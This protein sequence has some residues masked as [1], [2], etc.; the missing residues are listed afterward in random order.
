MAIGPFQV[1]LRP[2]KPQPTRLLPVGCGRFVFGQLFAMGSAVWLGLSQLVFGQ[3]I[4]LCWL[5]AQ[6]ADLEP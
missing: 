1:R 6:S 3:L 5:L 2:V 4:S